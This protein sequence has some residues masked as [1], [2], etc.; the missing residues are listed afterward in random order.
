M[1]NEWDEKYEPGELAAFEQA[2]RT[3][4]EARRHT[5]PLEPG[6]F[7]RQIM[8]NEPISEEQVA[9][10]TGL[11]PRAVLSLLNGEH[12]FDES[13]LARFESWLGTTTETLHNLQRMSDEFKRLGERTEQPSPKPD[14]RTVQFFASLRR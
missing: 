1:V 8:A 5:P 6:R 13:T 11:S 3:M 10:R 9:T 2:V 7:L 4:T 12:R 14:P